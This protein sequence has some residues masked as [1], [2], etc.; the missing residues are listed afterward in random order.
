MP[1][2]RVRRTLTAMGW[3]WRV[4]TH[5]DVPDWAAL[6]AAAERVDQTGEH[7]NEPDL[8]EELDEGSAVPEDRV[9]A[10]LAD[11][12][13]AFAAVRPRG[14]ATP[15]WRVEA[16]GMTDPEVRGHGLGAEGLAWVVDRA[17]QLRDERFPGA[18]TRIHVPAWLDNAGQVS[19]LEA[20]GFV[21]VNWSALM[22]IRFDRGDGPSP[23]RPTVPA[24]YRLHAY[25][26]GWS[27]ETLAAHNAA[28]VDHWGHVPWT[29]GGWKHWT[30]DT[31]NARHHLSWVLT[32]DDEP[33]R[34][35]A[36]A[37]TQEYDAHEQITGRREAYLAKLGVR[38]EHRGRGLASFLLRHGLHA[39]AQAGYDEAALDVD[40]NNPTGAFELYERVG[41][42]VDRRTATYEKVVAAL[43]PT[44]AAAVRR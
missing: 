35:A 25:D 23:A 6:M 30:D 17:S 33:Q 26:L 29:A 21:A 1:S 22:R 15:I 32:A 39:Y 27:A 5:D 28:F 14:E 40:T 4:I 20:A 7:Y 31:R 41:Y 9:G 36:Y 43:A 13:V 38:P 18:E 11:R 34:V 8:H 42:H 16:E 19:L 37:I 24:G 2:G 44:A 10:W 3:E 12:M